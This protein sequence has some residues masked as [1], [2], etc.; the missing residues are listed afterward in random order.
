MIDSCYFT[1]Q[2]YG[3]GFTSLHHL[4]ELGNLD[5]IQQFIDEFQPDIDAQSYSYLTPLHLTLNK[6]LVPVADLLII[7]GAD[8]EMKSVDDISWSSVIHTLH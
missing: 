3:A 2:D 5:H 7:N 4:V 1:L 6:N 8:T